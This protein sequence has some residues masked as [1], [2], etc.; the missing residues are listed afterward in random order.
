M[1]W[2]LQCMSV[3][4]NLKPIFFCMLINFNSINSALLHSNPTET[5]LSQ[6]RVIGITIVVSVKL[7]I[8]N[9]SV[10]R[11]LKYIYEPPA[12]IPINF[13]IL[14]WDNNWVGIIH[15]ID[16]IFIFKYLFRF[17]KCLFA[18]WRNMNSNHKICH[19]M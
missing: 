14:V 16:Q 8:E 15:K 5:L 11:N 13:T 3:A 9:M 17:F 2:K 10:A 4:R 18:H 7:W 6:S 19:T 1:S 12:C